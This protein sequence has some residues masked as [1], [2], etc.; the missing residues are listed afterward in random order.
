MENIEKSENETNVLERISYSIGCIRCRPSIMSCLT[1][2]KSR[3]QRISTLIKEPSLY[4]KKKQKSKRKI[5]KPSFEFLTFP[6]LIDSVVAPI[7]EPAIP[8]VIC[9]TVNSQL[10]MITSQLGEKQEVAIKTS[11]CDMEFI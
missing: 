5:T 11:F 6:L 9:K 7:K 4:K 3:D 1:V 2:H 8:N 10:T